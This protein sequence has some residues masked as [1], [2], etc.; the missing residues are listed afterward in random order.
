MKK[1]HVP[2]GLETRLEPLL[3]CL[4]S[5]E[6]SRTLPLRCRCVGVVVL[7]SLCRR[8]CVVVVVVEALDEL[9]VTC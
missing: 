4:C 7:W 2:G 3:L 5:F 8:R 1:K 9:A 6:P